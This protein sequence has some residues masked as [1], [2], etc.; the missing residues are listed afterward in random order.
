MAKGMTS[1]LIEVMPLGEVGAERWTSITPSPRC[2]KKLSQ[3]F[4]LTDIPYRTRRSGPL[5]GSA[6]VTAD[7]SASSRPSP[8][9]FFCEGCN[10]VRVTCTGTLYMC[11][12]Q[13]D[14]A[15]LRAPL[16]ASPDDAVLQAAMTA[17]PS[18]ASPRAT[19]SSSTAPPAPQPFP[20]T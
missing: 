7:G 9:N 10:R 13:E 20:A 4:T 2:A 5:C 19:T 16:R 15:D 1:R 14:A 11:L 3:R 18:T 8:H 17:E 6:G 12:G